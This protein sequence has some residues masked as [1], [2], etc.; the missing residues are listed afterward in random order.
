MREIAPFTAAML[1]LSIAAQITYYSG[2]IVVGAALGASSAAVFS[3][4]ARLVEGVTQPDQPVRR[5]LSAELRSLERPRPP[6]G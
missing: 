2:N 4:A 5:H 6:R 3:V 1:A